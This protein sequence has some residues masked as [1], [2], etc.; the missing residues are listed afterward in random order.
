MTTRAN[1]A[2]LSLLVAAIALQNGPA[3]A[4][5][6]G[7]LNCQRSGY[8]LT[9]N[10]ALKGPIDNTTIEDLSRILDESRRSVDVKQQPELFSHTEIELDSPGGSVLAAMA[11][12]RLLRQNRMIARVKPG[13]TCNSACVLV[14]AGAV[15]RFGHFKSGRIGIHQPYFEVPQHIA[16]AATI[17]ASYARM[18]REVRSYFR[19]MNVSE[20]LADEML[21]TPPASIRYLSS[22]E[23]EQFGLTIFD[24]VENE[25]TSIEAAQKLGLN[26]SEYIRRQ[27]ISKKACPP[28]VRFFH[29]AGKI[30]S[31]GKI[32]APDFS[33]FGTPVE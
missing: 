17:S 27:S 26:R 11:V 23:Q 28:D 32:S 33:A 20:Q 1:G 4:S 30:L 7:K 14:Y 18:L 21:R 19:E 31:T 6:E 13:A 3:I 9:E 15:G 24:P 2:L 25:I 8:C 29:C 5:V 16:D 10:L 12:G 22:L